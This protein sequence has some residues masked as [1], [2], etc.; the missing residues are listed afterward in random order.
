MKRIGQ[1]AARTAVRVAFKADKVT[2]QMQQHIALLEWQTGLLRKTLGYAAD[3]LRRAEWKE[4]VRGDVWK[5][6]HVKRIA[7]FFA[8]RAAPAGK[9]R[10]KP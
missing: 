7:R 10:R 5:L 6:A 1:K 9:P 3:L 4:R 8:P 2:K